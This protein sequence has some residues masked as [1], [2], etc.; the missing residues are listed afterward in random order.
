MTHQSD[1]IIIG[2]GPGGYDIAAE[3]A[4]DGFKVTLIERAELGGT[5]LNRGCI[6]TKCLCATAATAAAVNNAAAMGVITAPAEVNFATATSRMRSVV[7]RLRDGIAMLLKG[8]EVVHGEARLAVQEEAETKPSVI[9]GEDTYTAPK[10]IIATGSRP[11]LLPIEGAE[12]AAT[13]DEVLSL[14]EL[15]PRVCII[16]AGVIGMEFAGILSACGSEVTVLEYCPEI[17]PPFDRDVA[18]RLRSIM[19]RKGV[20]IVTGASVKAIKEG[21]SVTYESKKGTASVDC[22]LVV[23]AVGRRPVVPQGCEDSGIELTER[24]FIKTDD[25]FLTTAEGVYAVGDVNG[26]CMLA[27]AATAQA[28]VAMGMDVDLDLIPSAVFTMP[29]CAMVGL[30]EEQC[31]AEGL[32]YGIG[33][34]MFAANGKALAMDEGE[35]FVKVIYDKASRL[36]LGCH[37]IGPHAADIVAEATAFMYD[38][39]N[40]D[41]IAYG[42]VHGHP[43]LS[44]TLAAACAAAR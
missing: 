24:G 26:R 6:P 36:M 43:T 2:A 1:I 25:D 7:D 12:L 27:H 33:K 17:L 5:C 15:P 41:E 23:M 4:R 29:E 34:A 11:A 31:K 40:I 42:V 28:R 37:I 38:I 3:A 16:G 22:D 44:E 18:K 10:I 13:S 21:Y 9:V 30:T 39:T 20:K 14:T 32:S 8:V 35:G 19:S